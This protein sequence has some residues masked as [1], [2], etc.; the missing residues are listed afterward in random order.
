MPIDLPFDLTCWYLNQ[1]RVIE[2]VSPETLRHQI[3]AITGVS[4]R[5]R[6]MAELAALKNAAVNHFRMA[7]V[8]PLSKLAAQRKLSDGMLFTHHSNFW[9][10]GLPAIR[11]AIHAGRTPPLAVGYSKIPEWLSG[12]RIQLHF[13]HE[14]LTSHSAWSELSGQKRLMLF[15]LIKNINQETIEAIPYLIGSLAP[16][17]IPL[18][19]LGYAWHNHLELHID[20]ITSFE[21]A[22]T[23]TLRRSKA[24]LAGC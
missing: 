23:V 13:H 16:N 21:K 19:H 2:L 15:G 4:D 8:Q 24:V 10:K 7:Q 18:S 11:A 1:R 20:G 6:A 9:F 17:T 14:H 12:G 3:S 22:S 5:L